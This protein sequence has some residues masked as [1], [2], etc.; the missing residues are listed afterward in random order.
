MH[1]PCVPQR[2]TVASA[3]YKRPAQ[4][5]LGAGGLCLA[6]QVKYGAPTGTEFLWGM[7]AE[8]EYNNR[9]DELAVAESRKFR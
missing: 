5:D 4:Q 1:G 3:A 6:A 7:H 8:N 9:C 2:G